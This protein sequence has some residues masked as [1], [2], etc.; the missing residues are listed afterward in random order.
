MGMAEFIDQIRSQLPITRAVSQSINELIDSVRRQVKGEDD[1]DQGQE[2]T[3][4]G[5]AAAAQATGVGRLAVTNSGEGLV[6]L[7]LLGEG[8]FGKVSV[9]LSSARSFFKWN[10]NL[11]II[12]SGPSWPLARIVRGGQD[13]GP[14]QQ[15]LRRGQA[16]ADG[17]HGGGHQQLSVASQH[18]AGGNVGVQE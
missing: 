2:V 10:S 3:A 7:E 1:Y 15:P 8:A 14:P 4:A 11:K 6:V 18:R 16:R 13:N 12:C 17:H 5:A 9:L